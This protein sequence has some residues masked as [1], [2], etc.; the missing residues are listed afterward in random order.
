MANTK[1]LT[2]SAP[3]T[4]GSHTKWRVNLRKLGFWVYSALTY[5]IFAIII[6]FL[7]G[8]MYSPFVG[9]FY[10]VFLFVDFCVALALTSF[11][12]Q[13][14]VEFRARTIIVVTTVV[15]WLPASLLS[16]LI[17]SITYPTSYYNPAGLGFTNYFAMAASYMI[18]H[19]FLFCIGALLGTAV[20]VSYADRLKREILFTASRSEG[21][22]D[23]LKLAVS[24]KDD[25][26]TVT[27]GVLTLIKEGH[28]VGYLDDATNQL[29]ITS[30][31]LS[32][33]APASLAIPQSQG[34]VREYNTF[35]SLLIDLEELQKQGRINSASYDA[36]KQ[37]YERRLK[38]LESTMGVSRA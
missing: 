13:R 18:S 19:S 36:L 33:T 12:L 37:E 1:H 10:P 5:M 38:L 14:I 35:K 34:M 26:L 8:T 6:S 11:V 28:I 24:L 17:L 3:I 22:V 25:L 32:A 16:A 31:T 21:T 29:R 2:L 27:D 9:L 23:L 30:P 20:R 7:T 4:I 15:G